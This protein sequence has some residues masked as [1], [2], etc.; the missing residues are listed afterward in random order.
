MTFSISIETS[1]TNS[2]LKTIRLRQD[3]HS[4][5][6]I[7]SFG[8]LLGEWSISTSQGRMEVIDGYKSIED[9]IETV[10][11]GFKSAKLS[12]FVCRL[13]EGKYLFK[14]LPHTIE[15]HYIN[16]SAIHG[17]VYDAIYEITDH[18]FDEQHAFVQ[19]Q[20]HYQ[21][22]NQGFPFE[23]LINI[24]YTLRKNAALE[25]IT[26]ITNTG[27]TEMPLSD[28][29]HP[30]F[31]LGGKVNDQ[32]LEIKAEKTMVFNE[33][34]IPTGETK[35][36]SK[37]KSLEKIGTTELD[38]CFKLEDRSAYACLLLNPSNE[39]ELKIIA[40]SS[41]PYLQIYIP[42]QRSSI[43][44]ECLSSPPDSFNN[45]IDL[46]ILQPGESKNFVTNYILT[47]TGTN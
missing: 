22:K 21:E 32:E 9:A 25:I 34:L 40:D 20:Y 43:A 2:K 8:A 31:Q 42:P 29:W 41:Y 44:I 5:A 10:T 24:R 30:Y 33:K 18:G 13:Y 1:E 37:F 47:Q 36:F 26:T 39:L 11:D 23:Y 3:N 15:K 35:E 46:I 6:V 16:E 19:L 28:G 4:E 38:N 14:G 45:L 27:I 7:H 12:P 17:L